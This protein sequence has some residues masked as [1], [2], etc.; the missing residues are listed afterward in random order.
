MPDGR[1]RIVIIGAGIAGLFAAMMLAAQGRCII[2]VERD[3]TP[4]PGQD[5]DAAFA[6]R[7][8]RGVG[9]L[10]HS[11]AF[12]AR[13]VNL[14]RDTHPALLEA[15]KAAGCREVPLADFTPSSLRDRYAF[16]A[17]DE[18]LA[19]LVG[20]RTTFE[21]VLRRYVEALA[22]VEIRSGTFVANLAFADQE[23]LSAPTV[24]GVLTEAG[25]RLAADLVIDAAGRLSQAPDWLSAHGI[26]LVEAGEPTGV[27]YY[28]RHWRLN[29]GHA[30]PPRGRS[31]GAGDLGYL[32]FGLFEADEGWFSVTLAVAEAEAGLRRALPQPELFDAACRALPALAPWIEPDRA[33]PQT[34]V[35]GMGQLAS[36][37]R[38]LVKEGR[39]QVLGLL[40]AGD[41]LI[42]SNPIYGRG[43]AFAAVEAQALARTL[44]A[45]ADPATRTRLY[46]SLVEQ[47]LRPLYDDMQAQDRAA[48]RAAA[49]VRAGAPAPLREQLAQSFIRDGAGLA[50]RDDP[51]AFRAAMRGFHALEP[52]QAWIRAPRHMGLALRTWARGKRRNAH[53]YPG[54]LGPDR[55]EMLARLGLEDDAGSGPGDV[56]AA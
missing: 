40:L 21:A 1:E 33:T 54:P 15:W 4:E 50:V 5:A 9:Q 52:P 44:A 35:F 49:A 22:G 7:R 24:T 27:V 18:R 29:P 30:R 6:D 48:I 32:K 8:R 10:R 19:M 17:G 56:L 53:L 20:R 38:R 23:G 28:T 47:A 31:P 37:W 46:E 14:V 36:R 51:E 43:T 55:R 41:G 26:A 25:E 34:G 39:P 42:Q 3:P 12:L 11:H 13:L 2:L 45:T 16:E